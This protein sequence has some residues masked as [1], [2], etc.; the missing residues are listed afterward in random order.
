MVV[1]SKENNIAAEPHHFDLLSQNV[2]LQVYFIGIKTGSHVKNKFLQLLYWCLGTISS[3]LSRR[4]SIPEGSCVL[5]PADFYLDPNR[6]LTLTH[7]F[8]N[9]FILFSE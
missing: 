5:D 1:T 3:L 4:L 9:L 7:F 6:I 2:D 8:V